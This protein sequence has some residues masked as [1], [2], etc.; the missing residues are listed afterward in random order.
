MKKFSNI[1]MLYSLLISLLITTQNFSQSDSEKMF[2]TTRD[3]S[4]KALFA[5][6]NIF[7]E[8][9]FEKGTELLTDA[10]KL[11]K[12]N[13]K[14]EEIQQNLTMAVDLFNKSIETTKTLNTSFN[15][16]MKFRQLA[17]N[18]EAYNNASKLWKEG[19]ENFS[20]AVEDYND[21]DMEGYQKYAKAA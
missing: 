10:E 15:D 12:K 7:A 14:P 19:E 16:L 1:I 2:N 4:K 20:S 9:D 6:A 17:F 11:L 5:A 3:L 8:K 21:K 13:G 18:V